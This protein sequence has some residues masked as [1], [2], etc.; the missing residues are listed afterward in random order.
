[1]TK[2]WITIDVAASCDEGKA[3]LFLGDSLHKNTGSQKP[4]TASLV[5]VRWVIHT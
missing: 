4:R 5:A 3:S 2:G 1:M